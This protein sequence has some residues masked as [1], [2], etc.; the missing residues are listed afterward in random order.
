MKAKRD[1]PLRG[2]PFSD[3]YNFRFYTEYLFCFFTENVHQYSEKDENA[4]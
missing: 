4:A 1:S 2:G 3:E